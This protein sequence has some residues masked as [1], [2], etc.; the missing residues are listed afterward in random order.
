R[1]K[2]G[3]Q[4]TPSWHRAHGER[5]VLRWPR[6]AVERPLFA[7]FSERPCWLIAPIRPTTADGCSPSKRSASQPRPTTT[8]GPH[9]V[10]TRGAGISFNPSGSNPSPFA[11]PLPHLKC[12]RRR[13]S[14][15]R[16]SCAI[17]S[18]RHADRTLLA[19]LRC[20]VHLEC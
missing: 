4:L 6:R 17:P 20:N 10:V 16:T 12:R 7:H 19:G 11:F 18:P 8:D 1:P 3:P 15:A 13:T 5:A 14:P 9:S 2:P